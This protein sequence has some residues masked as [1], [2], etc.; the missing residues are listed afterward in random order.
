MAII[1]LQLP[2][3]KIL[4]TYVPAEAV[5][6]ESPPIGPDRWVSQGAGLHCH[7]PNKVGPSAAAVLVLA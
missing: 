6:V 1:W 2:G 7:W 3:T 4:Y 5:D